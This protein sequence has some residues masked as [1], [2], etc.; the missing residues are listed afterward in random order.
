MTRGR[1]AALLVAGAALLAA[2]TLPRV[3]VQNSVADVIAI[4]DIT[5]S[6]NVVDRMVGREPVSRLEFVK[7][8]LRR[9]LATLPCGSKLGLG[10]F[11]QY[12]SLVLLLPVEVCANR[13]ELE[14]SVDGI[15]GTMAWAGGSEIAKGLYLTLRMLKTLDGPPALAFFTDGHEAPPINPRHRIDV[16][17]EAGDVRGLLI[18]VGGDTPEPIPRMDPDG[19]PAGV[20]G[21]RDV[22]QEDR[23][24]HGRE[25]NV[26][27][28]LMDESEPSDA[29]PEAL[30]GTP[31]TE[32]LS[33][34]HERYL[35]V[36]AGESRLS[37]LR[38][39][40]DPGPAPWFAHAELA[41]RERGSA[42]LRWLAG[43][44]A[45]L[46]LAGPNAW[47][48]LAG[49]VQPRDPAHSGTRGFHLP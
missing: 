12:R 2:L 4:V 30:R 21:P 10:I 48:L 14:D 16:A 45:L 19:N 6:M 32:H 37:Y 17:G 20:W 18:G 35:E 31:G 28:E 25:G 13:A 46:A 36:L 9:A 34:L 15:Q 29:V 49:R 22:M 23:Y 8:A 44:A 3:A 27:N 42:D 40:A 1:R 26:A 41:R 7:H 39:A 47:R 5:Q 43:V 11:T 38:L 24:A 33:A